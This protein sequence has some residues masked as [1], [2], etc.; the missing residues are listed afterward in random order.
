MR[1]TARPARYRPGGWPRRGAW[2]RHF[3]RVASVLLMGIATNPLAAACWPVHRLLVFIYTMWLKRRTPQNIVIG[4]AAGAS[5]RL[6]AGPRD[7][8]HRPRA[9]DDVPDHLFLDAAAFLGA[10]A[11]GFQRTTSGWAC[12][13]SRSSPA[14]STRRHIPAYTLV[15]VRRRWCRGRCI[16]AGRCP[17]FQRQRWGPASLSSACGGCCTTGRTPQAASLTNDAPA[18][19]ANCS[20]TRGWY[21]SLC[22]SRRLAVDRAGGMTPWDNDLGAPPPSRL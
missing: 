19:A 5:R 12:P 18:L 1:R 10:V 4:G 7:R 16:M 6:S 13:C 15:L 21:T 8:H 14:R 20:A 17:G 9:A 11:L 22:Y 2:L 3:P